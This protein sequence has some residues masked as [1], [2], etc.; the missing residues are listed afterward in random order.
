MIIFMILYGSTKKF[1]LIYIFVLIH[2]M[3]HVAVAKAFGMKTDK[4]ILSGLGA[5]AR[6]IN[7]NNANMQ[8][9]FLI[10]IAGPLSN[11]FLY[12]TFKFFFAN[13]FCAATNIFLCIFNLLPV[14]PLDG[15]RIFL[16]ALKKMFGLKANKFFICFNHLF[17]IS[18]IFLG[19]FQFFIFMPNFSL[20]AIALYLTYVNKKS[21]MDLFCD[22]YLY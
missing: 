17:I 22:L 11:L 1:F 2:E 4:I 13:K 15:G 16:L 7:F 3:F 8:K 12:L 19:I 14:Y 20:F 6:I 5:N 10:L 18:F 9:K 21:F